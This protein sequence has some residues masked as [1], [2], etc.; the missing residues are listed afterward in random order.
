MFN[1]ALLESLPNNLPARTP[2]HAHLLEY[3]ATGEGAI[4][5]SFLWNPEQI[6]T[7]KN[8]KYSTANVIGGLPSV[9][10]SGEELRTV[11]LS[12]IILEGFYDGKDVTDLAVGLEMLTKAVTTGQ[13][14]AIGEAGDGFT[15]ASPP[16]LS[17][18]LGGRVVI[19]PCVVVSTSRSETAFFGDGRIA[20]C[21]VSFTLQEVSTRDLVD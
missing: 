12:N 15:F 10:Y 8:A 18:V 9:E 16:V 14:N 1:K 20:D 5:W 19:A 11:S 13:T 2:V 6:E 7:Q 4:A 3:S 17:F 21:T